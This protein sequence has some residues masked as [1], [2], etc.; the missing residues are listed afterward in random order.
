[1]YL[2]KNMRGSILNDYQDAVEYDA[3][4]GLPLAALH[5]LR[6]IPTLLQSLEE[7][8]SH[9]HYCPKCGDYCKEC[10]CMEQKI[11]QLEEEIKQ[12][13]GK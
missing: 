9:V 2:D 5:A 11:K 10:T 13:R 8:E 7:M 12:L 1:M 4:R 6:W 3:E